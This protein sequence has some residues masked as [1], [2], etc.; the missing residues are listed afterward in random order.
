MSE[1]TESILRVYNMK[2]VEAT[3][4]F[5]MRFDPSSGFSL[6]YLEITVN[7]SV[8]AKSRANCQKPIHRQS[9]RIAEKLRKHYDKKNPVDS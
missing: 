3:N 1:K 6:N 4:P 5:L 9:E 7:Q 2:I 8:A